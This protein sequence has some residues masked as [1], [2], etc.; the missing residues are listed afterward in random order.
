M[1][2]P[3]FKWENCDSDLKTEIAYCIGNVFIYA[4]LE[5]I[6]HFIQIGFLEVLVN[7]LHSEN[8]LQVNVSLTAI[9]KVFQK[10]AKFNKAAKKLKLRQNTSIFEEF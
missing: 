8:L 5:L 7:S 4:N 9:K 3:L 1:L 10:T 6:T 2:L